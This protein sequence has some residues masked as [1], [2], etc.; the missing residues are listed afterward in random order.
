MAP[1]RRGGD[2]PHDHDE[3]PMKRGRRRRTIVFWVLMAIVV[4][5][6]AARGLRELP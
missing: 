1:A 2:L 5:A 4:I 6:Y 3:K